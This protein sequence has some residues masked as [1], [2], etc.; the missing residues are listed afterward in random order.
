MGQYE[1]SVKTR[2]MYE[3]ALALSRLGKV[4]PVYKPTWDEQ[5]NAICSCYAADE[6][7]VK[8]G[9]H[10]K[11]E[12]KEKATTDPQTI[13]KLWPGSMDHNIAL[14]TDGLLIID[15]DEMTPEEFQ[16][17]YRALPTTRVSSTGRGQH[18]YYRQ[19]EGMN[20]RNT[21][22][23]IPGVDTRASG[24]CVIVPPSLHASG[25]RYQWV[26]EGDMAEAPLWL[27]TLF[28]PKEEV[29]TAA[30]DDRDITEGQRN[31]WL[32]KRGCSMRG[33]GKNEEEILIV[34]HAINARHCMPPLDEKEVRNI[35][36]SAAKHAANDN[37]CKVSHS[38]LAK[39]I[40][41]WC[42]GHYAYNLTTKDWYSYKQGIWSPV[43]DE[44]M[45]IRR[46]LRNPQTAL[47]F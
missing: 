44:L 4:F 18:W 29:G 6:C 46:Y 7:K 45:F 47:I 40:S 21:A 2:T 10:P 27:V 15:F 13:R 23:N 14:A 39:A 34:L 41:G 37:L 28:L 36:H 35:A 11:V 1:E 31:D 3:E 24:G 30:R 19:P 32:Y 8:P 12:W 22:K 43:Y 33:R 17:A 16:N 26:Y 42:N 38:E 20:I 25:E 5:G 9:K